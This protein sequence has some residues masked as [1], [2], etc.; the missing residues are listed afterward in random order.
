MRVALIQ[1]TYDL[2]RQQQHQYQQLLDENELELQYL[3]RKN[4]EDY[5]IDLKQ[6]IQK[7]IF[8]SFILG[9]FLIFLTLCMLLII[10]SFIIIIFSL[11]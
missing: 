10:I 3:Q 1:K 9:G 5:I 7:R 6:E 11:N 2:F 4:E 8:A